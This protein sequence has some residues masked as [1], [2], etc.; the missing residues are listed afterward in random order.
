ML[1]FMLL[2]QMTANLNDCGIILS[3]LSRFISLFLARQLQCMN[4]LVRNARWPILFSS[5]YK[6]RDT[7]YSM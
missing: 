7:L 2:E 4:S 6:Y 3:V 5:G 1:R